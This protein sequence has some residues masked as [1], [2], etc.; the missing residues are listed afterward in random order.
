V[1]ESG[2]GIE[3]G[4][5]TL[6]ALVAVLV[7]SCGVRYAREDRCTICGHHLIWLPRVCLPCHFFGYVPPSKE[8]AEII[9]GKRSVVLPEPTLS[10][11]IGTAKAI[12]T[13]VLIQATE[14]IASSK[15]LSKVNSIRTSTCNLGRTVRGEPAEGGSDGSSG[16]GV[17]GAGGV[18]GLRPGS[19]KPTG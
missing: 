13:K 6:I 10:E 15:T 12:T 11:R 1:Y 9:G 4:W 5:A 14:G 19:E 7:L 18:S 17:R 3:A 16:K 8:V 2:S